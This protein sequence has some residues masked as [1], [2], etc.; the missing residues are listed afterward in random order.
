MINTFTKALAISTLAVLTSAC[1]LEN[2]ND[3]SIT[4][5][6]SDVSLN[7]PDPLTKSEFIDELLSIDEFAPGED[8]FNVL[9]SSDDFDDDDEFDQCMDEKAKQVTFSRG[10]SQGFR[11]VMSQGQLEECVDLD[12]VD[13]EKVV[14][15]VVMDNLILHDNSGNEVSLSGKNITQT[16]GLKVAQG[17]MNLYM[18]MAVSTTLLGKA[19][20]VSTKA[21]MSQ[22]H[23]SGINNPCV[24]TNPFD[25]CRIADVSQTTSSTHPDMAGEAGYILLANNLFYNTGDEY[26]YNGTIEFTINDW[27][28]TAQYGSDGSTPPIIQATNGSDTVDGTYDSFS[29]LFFK[30]GKS[31]DI[32]DDQLS[33]S[34][35]KQV[36][37][38]F[39]SQ[40]LKKTESAIKN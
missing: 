10:S 22:N 38:N 26:F 13:V 27:E 32:E 29:S 2:D 1:I 25:S 34:T 20:Q 31:G 12:G 4:V 21:A 11:F 28:G 8:D 16:E 6:L 19:T 37:S 40:S 23:T 17:N 18:E 7:S 9:Y 14:I 33:Q 39:I 30:A 24:L 36:I 5:S 35:V 3:N 15:Q